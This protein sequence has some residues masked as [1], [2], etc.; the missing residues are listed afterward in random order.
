M[1]REVIGL[2]RNKLIRRDPKLSLRKT[3]ELGMV[4]NNE[5]YR[6]MDLVRD[7]NMSKSY[8]SK[9]LSDLLK[10]GVVSRILFE[11][12]YMYGLSEV[13]ADFVCEMKK[14]DEGED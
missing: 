1:K 3:I 7:F 11:N 14:I 12:T 5:L 2:V 4:N 13:L 6:L 9:I 8:A 10:S